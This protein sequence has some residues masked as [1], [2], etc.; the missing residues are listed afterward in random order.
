MTTTAEGFYAE[1][2]V[3]DSAKGGHL[4]HWRIRGTDTAACGFQPKAKVLSGRQMAPRHGWHGKRA[5]Y[6]LC[7]KCKECAWVDY[8]NGG[9]SDNDL[10]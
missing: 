8:Q 1:P 7:Q 10:P 4:N 5:F 2:Y 3:M 6:S 9:R